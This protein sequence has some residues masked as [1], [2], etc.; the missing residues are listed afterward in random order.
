MY[1]LISSITVADGRRD[2]LA[3]ILIEAVA[4]MP[5]CLSYVVAL[6]V[7]DTDTIWVTEVWDTKESHDASLSL[8]AVRKAIAAAKPIIAG[9]GSQTIT[10]PLGGY[11]LPAQKA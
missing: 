8:P 10:A 1:G 6:D 4:D 11:G 9:F 3:A 5:G 2:E 7:K